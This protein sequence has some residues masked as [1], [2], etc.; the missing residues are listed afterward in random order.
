MKPDS[1]FNNYIRNHKDPVKIIR[2][3]FTTQIN[4]YVVQYF[5]CTRNF[6]QGLDLIEWASNILDTYR[7]QFSNKE[8]EVIKRKLIYG[9]LH[10]L[11]YLNRW[12][13][14]IEYYEFILLDKDY[15][16]TYVK[17]RDDF[18]FNKFVVKEDTNFKYVH[19]LYLSNHRYK[20]IKKKFH[21]WIKGNNTEY[22]NRHQKDKLT[23]EEINQRTIDIL[24]SLKQFIETNL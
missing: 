5:Q 16:L 23:D 17:S 8:Y 22:L 13:E 3:I 7:N 15:L 19:F 14:Y 9:K 24:T 11:D 12:P 6:D 10:Y 2:A 21:K 4:N 1:N 18:E 20:I